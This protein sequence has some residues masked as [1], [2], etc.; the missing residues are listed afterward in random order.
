VS[1]G[2]EAV[3]RE[4]DG[5]ARFGIVPGLGRMRRLLELLDHPQR[6]FSV[7][8]VAGT[9]G[10]GTCCFLID[11]LLGLAGRR[12]G[13]YVSPHL[14]SPLER[15]RIDGTALDERGLLEAWEELEAL[16]PEVDPSYFELL[17]ALALVAFRRAKVEWAVVE[18]G[19]G[20]SFDA[21]SALDAELA[22]ITG[23]ALD[24]TAVLGDSLEEIARDKAGIARPGRALLCGEEDPVLRRVIQS[25][26]SARGAGFRL[27]AGDCRWTDHGLAGGVLEHPGGVGLNLLNPGAAWRRAAAL[28]LEALDLLEAKVIGDLPR[29]E[30]AL[31]AS[32]E[33]WPGRFQVLRADPPLLLDV[34]HNP[35]AAAAL[36]A[37]LLRFWPETR[38]EVYFAAMKDKDIAGMLRG[39]APAVRRLRPLDLDHPRAAPA[40]ELLRAAEAAGLPAAAPVGSGELAELAE[41]IEAQAAPGDGG[42]RGP[43]FGTPLLVTGSFLAVSAWLSKGRAALPPGL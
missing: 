16:L 8:H 6:D 18:C 37:D 7:I 1:G 32:P 26:C 10:K 35:S 27:P 23:V 5:R 13:L 28:A 12:T 11:R 22:V 41:E 4:I 20:G 9:N 17:T 2:L 15:V 24:H 34:A 33:D 31:H 30:I 39:P 21:T 43:I 19:L 38:F 3:W 29:R 40:I 36:A 42:A 14:L 25:V